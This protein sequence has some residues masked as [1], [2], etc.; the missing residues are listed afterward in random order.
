MRSLHQS[1]R[2]DTRQGGRELQENGRHLRALLN[3]EN[4]QEKHENGGLSKWAIRVLGKSSQRYAKSFDVCPAEMASL[5]R[6]NF[7]CKLQQL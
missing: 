3:H 7:A 2:A 1:H 5:A 6:Y 4:G